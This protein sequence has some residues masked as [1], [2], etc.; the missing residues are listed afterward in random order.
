[1]YQAHQFRFI[2]DIVYI[3]SPDGQKCLSIANFNIL[4]SNGACSDSAWVD[5][6]YFLAEPRNDSRPPYSD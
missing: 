4:D 1:M 5:E 2:V 3:W 6:I